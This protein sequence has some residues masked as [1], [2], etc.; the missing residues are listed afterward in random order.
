MPSF[1]ET[2]TSEEMTPTT[3]IS[4]RR[5][6]FTLPLSYND[7]DVH[8]DPQIL[9]HKSRIAYKV[10]LKLKLI[11]YRQSVGQSVLVSGAH[12]GPEPNFFLL[13]EIFFRHLRAC[14]FVAPSLTR[15]RIC[16]LLLLLSSPEQSRSSLSPTGLNTRFYCPNC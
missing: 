8:T 14:Y 2:R 15:G 11:Y 5:D 10:K 4:Y 3:I 12:L 6:V 9:L 7:S 1:H 16:N 13:I